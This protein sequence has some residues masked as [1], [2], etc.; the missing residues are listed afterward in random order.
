MK[1]QSLAVI[2]LLIIIPMTIILTNYSKNQIRT[3][4]FQISFDTKLKTST[5]D[6]I[7]AFQLNMY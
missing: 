6:A 1:I 3:L 7:K 4:Q 5:Y 2:A